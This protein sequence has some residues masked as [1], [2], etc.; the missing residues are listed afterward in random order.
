MGPSCF[1]FVR[2]LTGFPLSDWVSLPELS[3]LFC[4]ASRFV[5]P[6]AYVARFIIVRME[7]PRMG[8]L[9]GS[10]SRGNGIRGAW[11]DMLSEK[12]LVKKSK[13]TLSRARLWIQ[14]GMEDGS[15]YIKHCI[16]VHYFHLGSTSI[17]RFC[18]PPDP[19]TGGGAR[20]SCSRRTCDIYIAVVLFFV[21]V[22]PISPKKK[23]VMFNI[24]ALVRYSLHKEKIH[25]GLRTWSSVRQYLEEKEFWKKFKIVI[26][27][28]LRI[29]VNN[30]DVVISRKNIAY[31]FVSL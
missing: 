27:W 2:T 8:R 24:I 3:I 26:R 31:S 4:I 7:F 23:L 22:K 18:G 11:H 25:I 6:Y 16:K 14:E 21:Q 13:N 30:N 17:S 28:Y 5:W 10:M 1:W 12:F 29:L 15:L 19:V 9:S 20:D